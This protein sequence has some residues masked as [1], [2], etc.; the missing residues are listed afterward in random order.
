MGFWGSFFTVKVRGEGVSGISGF[1]GFQGFRVSGFQG[2]RVS[3]F[4][5][6]RVSVASLDQGDDFHCE[7]AGERRRK[8]FLPRR[9]EGARARGNFY[10]EGAGGREREGIFIV[11]VRE[12]GGSNQEGNK[13]LRWITSTKK[14]GPEGRKQ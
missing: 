14:E 7:G 4:Q 2:F 12:C 10:L 13:L 5:S 8:G 6:F 9:R 3:E 11:K 1:Q